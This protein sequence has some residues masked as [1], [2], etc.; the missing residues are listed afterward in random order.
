VGVLITRKPNLIR[1]N[2]PDQVKSAAN[3]LTI[4]E[5][6]QTI[7][8]LKTQTN[9]NTQYLEQLHKLFFTDWD[10]NS[11]GLID[12]LNTFEPQLLSQVLAA[13]EEIR[14]ELIA[15]KY[16]INNPH[17]VTAA[18]LGITPEYLQGLILV[19]P[20]SPQIKFSEDAPTDDEILWGRVTG[21]IE[22]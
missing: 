7:N 1:N 15:H 16:D 21:T 10:G 11:G 17:Q 4:Q 5:W 13:I 6:N 19:Q 3:S 2:I 20:S 9:L 18:Q 14:A 8:I 22:E 12:A